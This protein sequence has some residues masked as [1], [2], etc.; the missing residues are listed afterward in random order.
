MQTQIKPYC[1]THNDQHKA[2]KQRFVRSFSEMFFSLLEDDEDYK[3]VKQISEKLNTKSKDFLVKAL[4]SSLSFDFISRQ[5]NQYQ[6]IL[7]LKLGKLKDEFS[8]GM[9]NA[10]VAASRR[11]ADGSNSL[12]LISEVHELSGNLAWSFNLDTTTNTVSFVKPV[13]AQRRDIQKRLPEMVVETLN[14][15]EQRTESERPNEEK[16]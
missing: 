15:L 9:D 13:N 12:R 7:K 5:E 4:R 16:S 8:S 2:D 3:R 6:V 14:K 11:K 1:S 10:V